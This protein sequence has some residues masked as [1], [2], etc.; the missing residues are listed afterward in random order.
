MRRNCVIIADGFDREAFNPSRR[1]SS[2]RI[3]FAMEIPARVGL[4]NRSL[5]VTRK[6]LRRTRV[7]KFWLEKSE[8]T[9]IQ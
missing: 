4:F 3:F 5:Q 1:G 7:M 9:G 6:P 2:Y 8:N